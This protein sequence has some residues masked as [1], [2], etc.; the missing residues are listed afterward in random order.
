MPNLPLDGK[1]GTAELAFGGTGTVPVGGDKIF[2]FYMIH[3]PGLVRV[4]I[5]TD[6]VVVIIDIP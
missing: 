4:I 6:E 3:L 5:M 2:G 1:F